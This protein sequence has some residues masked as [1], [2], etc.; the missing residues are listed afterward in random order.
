MTISSSKKINYHIMK[1]IYLSNN[2]YRTNLK[3]V[4]QIY[5]IEKKGVTAY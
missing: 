2:I 4:I 5:K 3:I 1:L